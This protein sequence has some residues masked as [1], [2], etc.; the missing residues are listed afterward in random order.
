MSSQWPVCSAVFAAFRCSMGSIPVANILRASARR[1]L[2]KARG[3]S[4]YLPN[5]MSFALPSYRKAHR[6]SFP[7]AGVT[8][9]YILPLS[10]S[11]YGLSFAFALLISS[12]E[13]ALVGPYWT[14]KDE[15]LSIC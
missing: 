13:M 2:A 10:L 8:Q 15:N 6:Q 12:S 7:P 4:G 11:L 9:R 3:T 14:Q 5:V 1:S